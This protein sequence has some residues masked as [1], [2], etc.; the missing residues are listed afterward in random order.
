MDWP[1]SPAARQAAATAAADPAAAARL[2][3]PLTVVDALGACAQVAREAGRAAFRDL[4]R[5]FWAADPSAGLA[6]TRPAFAVRV[7]ERGFVP[8]ADTAGVDALDYQ[9]ARQFV[10][11]V[12]D[13]PPLVE[14]LGWPPDPR[15]IAA[16]RPF[17]PD[18]IRGVNVL[19]QRICAAAAAHRDKGPVSPQQWALLSLGGLH[20]LSRA[21]AL[22]RPAG[23]ST[24]VHF[25]RGVLHAAGCNVLPA[26][27]T[28]TAAGPGGLFLALP[29]ETF[30]YVPAAAMDRGQRPDMGDIFHVQGASYRD[31]DGNPTA[32]STHVGVIVG[33]WGTIWLTVE[34]GTGDHVTRQRTRE[35]VPVN[36]PLG[37]WGLKYDEAAAAVGP[38][39]LQGWYSVARMR[40]DLW[41]NPP[42][43]VVSGVV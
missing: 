39:P 10:L 14:A 35:L 12:R 1:I 4:A 33:V 26:G 3:R 32:D 42:S 25:A 36:S 23:G 38:R 17:Y 34:G 37:K 20:P 40:P 28:A 24:S 22:A 41:M 6:L 18:L 30:G 7:A 27:N 8:S 13:D 43:E 29:K 11:K 9:F 21:R 5:A 15:G 2:L 16:S 31:A 19:R